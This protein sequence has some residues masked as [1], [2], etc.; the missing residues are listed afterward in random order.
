VLAIAAAVLSLFGGISGFVLAPACG[1]IAL[2]RI[3]RRPD[4]LRG[5]WLAQVAVGLSAL[6]L[7]D[8]LATR[9]V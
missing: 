2:R 5:A 4:G 7:V 6:R 8:Y 3:M 9:G 1:W